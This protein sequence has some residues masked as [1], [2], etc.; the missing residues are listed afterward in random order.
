MENKFVEIGT[1][2]KTIT[3]AIDNAILA[4]RAKKRNGDCQVSCKR[5]FLFLILYTD[6]MHLIQQSTDK[7]EGKKY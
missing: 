1:E 5:N 7:K 2:I 4:R 3:V 6:Q